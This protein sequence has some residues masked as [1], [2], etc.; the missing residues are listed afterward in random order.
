MVVLLESKKV[1]KMEEKWVE[2]MVGLKADYWV[3]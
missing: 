3:A 1:A 2:L